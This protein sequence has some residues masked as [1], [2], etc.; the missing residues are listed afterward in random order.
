V[1][2]V[3]EKSEDVRPVRDIVDRLLIPNDGESCPQ[4]LELVVAE[5]LSGLG[6]GRV[7]DASAV[8]LG[9]PSLGEADDGRMIGEAPR[10]LFE[11]L[12]NPP[13]P[14]AV[15]PATARAKYSL[16]WSAVVTNLEAIIS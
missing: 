14:G 6:G 13:L 7:V 12:V 8:R 4:L 3:A 1:S 2:L 10:E 5:Q 9:R 16:W 15:R 11:K